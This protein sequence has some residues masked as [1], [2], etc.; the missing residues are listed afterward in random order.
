MA[1]KQL[2]KIELSTTR[3][4]EVRINMRRATFHRLTQSIMPPPHLSDKDEYSRLRRAAAAFR[5]ATRRCGS[6]LEHLKR[7]AGVKNAD[8]VRKTRICC[9]CGCRPSIRM[10]PEIL[11]QVCLDMRLAVSTMLSNLRMKA[12]R[13]GVEYQCDLQGIETQYIDVSSKDNHDDFELCDLPPSIP[14]SFEPPRPNKVY[15]PRSE[16]LGSRKKKKTPKKATA[17]V[18]TCSVLE[19]QPDT[20]PDIVVTCDEPTNE[21]VDQESPSPKL[22]TETKTVVE[23]ISTD[24]HVSTATQYDLKPIHGNGGWHC[25]ALSPMWQN[26]IRRPYHNVK[27][28]DFSDNGLD[29]KSELSDDMV[30][31]QDSEYPSTTEPVDDIATLRWADSVLF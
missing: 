15:N 31:S 9:Q 23:E 17:T 22:E 21:T 1:A 10:T 30:L 6:G 11:C 26:I 19:Y 16:Q 18:T 28:V 24:A 20:E 5:A 29:S 7:K 2:D 12:I 8:E 27:L 14:L 13:T 3:V 25:P 4:F